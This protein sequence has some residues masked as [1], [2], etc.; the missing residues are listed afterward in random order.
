MIRRAPWRAKDSSLRFCWQFFWYKVGTSRSSR[1]FITQRV[2]EYEAVWH[3]DEWKFL[4]ICQRSLHVSLR[5]PGE[6]EQDP[7]DPTSTT[8][9]QQTTTQTAETSSG[10]APAMR[11]LTLS[12]SS[13]HVGFFFCFCYHRRDENMRYVFNCTQCISCLYDI[14][15]TDMSQFV[16]R[17]IDRQI[18]TDAVGYRTLLSSQ[19]WLRPKLGRS[20]KVPLFAALSVYV[21]LGSHGHLAVSQFQMIFSLIL[22][23]KHQ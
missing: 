4:D 12:A 8:T 17:Q 21:L 10:V 15:I 2:F 3:W 16:Y 6:P 14:D 11:A 22:T 18:H 13:K 23:I 7:S 5:F 19:P 1:D 9:T 20:S